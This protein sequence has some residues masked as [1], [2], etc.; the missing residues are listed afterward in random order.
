MIV[1]YA[2][3]CFNISFVNVSAIKNCLYKCQTIFPVSITERLIFCLSIQLNLN[4]LI[5]KDSFKWVNFSNSVEYWSCITSYN[6]MVLLYVSADSVLQ[7]LAYCT[8][9]K[10]TVCV[11]LWHP[12]FWYRGH[13]VTINKKQ[14]NVSVFLYDYNIF[15][16]FRKI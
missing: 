12:Y 7:I 8:Y 2:C 10:I 16:G 5:F 15:T 13:G 6:R 4:S 1:I 3:S 14:A 9:I 11:M